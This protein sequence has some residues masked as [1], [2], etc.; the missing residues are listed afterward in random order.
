[1]PISSDDD[2]DSSKK[3]D[4]KYVS[5]HHSDVDICM[6]DDEGA[7]DGIDL[8][9]DVDMESNGEDD[10]EED[11]DEEDEEKDDEDEV[12]EED[13]DEEEDKDEDEGKEP[14]TICQGEM[15]NPLAD[16]ADTMVGDE[17][18]IQCNH[19]QDMRK[20]T[21]R[22]QP[23]T[24]TPQP[25]TLEPPLPPQTPGTHT[26]SGLEILPLM[27]PQKPRPA[28]LTLQG[29]KKAR[30]T[31]DDGVEQQLLGKSARAN[32]LPDIPLL[33]FPL[34]NVP[35]PD[36][37]LAAARL[38]VSADEYRTSPHIA[39]EACVWVTVGFLT[40]EFLLL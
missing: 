39:E 21:P 14:R 19:V 9:G 23:P 12:E 30:N 20:Y 28:A 1:M 7:P 17:P 32:S 13:E 25:Q 27:T 29:A 8:D 38:D 4:S 11:E 34:P 18:I 36:A 10:E 40:C 35:L 22:P 5:Q 37:P 15:V 6:E 2:A 3:S 31:S 33:D 16:D 26:L 24:P